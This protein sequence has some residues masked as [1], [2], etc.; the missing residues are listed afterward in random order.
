[1]KKLEKLVGLM[2]DQLVYG[3]LKYLG[4][5][6][7]DCGDHDKN[8]PHYWPGNNAVCEITSAKTVVCISLTGEIHIENSDGSIQVNLSNLIGM[9][10]NELVNRDAIRNISVGEQG[11]YVISAMMG[12]DKETICYVHGSDLYKALCYGFIMRHCDGTLDVPDVLVV[13]D[14][15][16]S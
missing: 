11:E 13:G 9:H 14:E 3:V 6:I 12:T 16:G 7:F 5:E 15:S 8:S 1:M 4:Y 10:L 2:D